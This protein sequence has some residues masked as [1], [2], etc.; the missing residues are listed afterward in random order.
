MRIAYYLDRHYSAGN[1]LLKKTIQQLAQW[2][3]AGHRCQL[4]AVTK[5]GSSLDECSTFAPNEFSQDGNR[6]AFYIRTFRSK[7]KQILARIHLC[8]AVKRWEPDVVYTRNDGLVSLVKVLM[9]ASFVS[10]LEVNTDDIGE[11][12]RNHARVWTWWYRFSRWMLYRA[13][14]GL[15]FVTNEIAQLPHFTC[16]SKPSLVCPNGIP[17]ANFQILPPSGNSR[18][19]FVFIGSAGHRWH[20]VDKLIMLAEALP[21]YEFEVIGPKAGDYD[22]ELPPN[23]RFHGF[24]A[25][26]QYMPILQRS[27]VA[28]GTLAMHRNMMNEGST[29][30]VREYLA[31]GLPCVIAYQDTDFPK[32]VAFIL[33]LPN[34]ENNITSEVPRILKFANEW[35]N[36]RVPRQ[37]ISHID[38]GFKESRRLEFFSQLVEHSSGSARVGLVDSARKRNGTNISGDGVV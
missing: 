16:F 35:T 11:Y 19:H 27:D 24:L 7:P 8:S 18:P 2:Q 34:C 14:S 29:L 28:I 3:A 36:H 1:S 10:V 12:G 5:E 13:A 21:E 23:L 30:K 25:A 17:L 15:V 32:P 9:L 22:K 6:L 26:G 38:A 20:G 4:F 33:T 37:V 31:H